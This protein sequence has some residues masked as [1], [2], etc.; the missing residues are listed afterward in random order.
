MKFRKPKKG[1]RYD[2]C[3]A[4]DWAPSAT[5]SIDQVINFSGAH[6]LKSGLEARCEALP[7]VELAQLCNGHDLV[8]LL[9]EA[10]KL[11]S[12]EKQPAEEWAE[13]L[14]TACERRWLQGTEMW[15]GLQA[16]E[17]TH[18]GFHILSAA[19]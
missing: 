18:P 15:K 14:A 17:A 16:W 2:R 5:K 3:T 10:F 4:K 11:F 13:R 12:N 6:H 7:E 19:A 9:T 1:L 8:G